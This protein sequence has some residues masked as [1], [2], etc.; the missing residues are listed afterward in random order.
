MD[1]LTYIRLRFQGF[2]HF[3]LPLSRFLTVFP[4]RL[5]S[6]ASFKTTPSPTISYWYKPHTSTTRKP[7]LFVHGIGIGLWPYL[8]FL[9]EI[10]GSQRDSGDGDIGVIA[11]ELMPIS[12]RITG[13]IPSQ[14]TLCEEIMQ[15][16]DRHGWGNFELVSNSYGTVVTTNILK[17]R[18]IK[19]RINSIVLIDP[20]TILL[21]LPDVAYNFTRRPPRKA[22]EHQLYYFASTDVCVANSLGRHFFWVENILWKEAIRD[23]KVTVVLSGRDLITNTQAVGKYLAED[24][25]GYERFLTED[26]SGSSEID[27][28]KNRAWKGE[29]LDIVWFETLDHAQVFEKTKDYR[30]LV[31]IVRSYS[32]DT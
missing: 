4:F 18:N 23:Y 27:I 13:E 7:I 22:N 25:P 10:N 11:I 24:E 12:S 19:S 14:K 30:R 2:Q 5:I 28:W 29:G 3:R 16:V 17:L 31:D 6:L 21:H 1:A 15:I 8:N 26:E 32:A 20:V 9:T